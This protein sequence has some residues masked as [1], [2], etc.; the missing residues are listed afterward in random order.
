M[1]LLA[2]LVSVKA[3]PQ[4]H[5]AFIIDSQ[6]RGAYVN[7]GRPDATATGPAAW[8]T[9]PTASPSSLAGG[10]LRQLASQTARALQVDPSLVDAVIRA[11]SAYNARARSPKGALGLMQ[12]IPAT[13]TRFGVSN[14]FDPADN[15]RGGVTYL[16]HLLKRFRGDVPLSLAAYNA[17]EGDVLREGGIPPFAETR[18]YVR[19]IVAAYPAAVDPCK[20]VAEN[21]QAL[22]DGSADPAPGGNPLGPAP[23]YRTSTE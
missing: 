21:R 19:K 15:L 14:P 16:G 6:G 2:L 5:I 7:A 18:Q 12:L 4:D 3:Y 22:P 13:A 20:A 9:P 1:A 17:G 11:E 8:L 23:I 10:D